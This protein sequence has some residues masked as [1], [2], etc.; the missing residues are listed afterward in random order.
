MTETTWTSPYDPVEVGGTTF[1]D[2]V[3]ETAARH[4]D[5]VAFV[6]GPG[7]RELTYATLADRADRVAATLTASGFGAGEARLLDA[8]SPAHRVVDVEARR[9][10]HDARDMHGRVG[11]ARDEDG[12]RRVLRSHAIGG[13][14]R[15]GVGERGIA[16]DPLVFDAG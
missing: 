1:H 7:G 13:A 2:L 3:A 16:V 10:E 5:R 12:V 8:E 6:D 4:G 14:E 11:L 15:S 9:G